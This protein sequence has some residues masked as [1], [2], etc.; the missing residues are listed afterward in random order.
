MGEALCHGFCRVHLEVAVDVLVGDTL[1]VSCI[2]PMLVA[3]TSVVVRQAL[4]RPLLLISRVNLLIALCL[5]QHLGT[6]L[7]LPANK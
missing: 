6:Q 1:H 5:P 3:L 4:T 2:V 7:T